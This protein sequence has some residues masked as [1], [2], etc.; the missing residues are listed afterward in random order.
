MLFKVYFN[1]Q[2]D[3]EILNTICKSYNNKNRI[4]FCQ[5]FWVPLF[6]LKSYSVPVI[7]MHFA[8]CQI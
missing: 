8:L 7:A 1:M 4:T 2:S 3:N 5:I 6:K